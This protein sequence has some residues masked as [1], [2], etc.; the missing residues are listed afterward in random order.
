MSRLR[1]ALDSLFGES[2][3]ARDA[4]LAVASYALAELSGRLSIAGSFPLLWLPTGLLAGVLVRSDAARW[5]GLVAASIAASTAFNV[6]RGLGVLELVLFPGANV[7]PATPTSPT[8]PA[9]C[10]ASS[11]KPRPKSPRPRALRPWAAA[12]RFCSRP[13]ASLA[14]SLPCQT[15]RARLEPSALPRSTAGLIARTVKPT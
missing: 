14:V 7:L 11:A 5:P 12:C 15:Y 6:P 1:Q 4:L 8:S 2:A 10:G 9:R 13:A 3:L